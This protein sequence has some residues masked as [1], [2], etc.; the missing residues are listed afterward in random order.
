MTELR[1][2]PKSARISLDAATFAKAN[3]FRYYS[4]IQPVT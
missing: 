1:T 3:D 4:T 2:K